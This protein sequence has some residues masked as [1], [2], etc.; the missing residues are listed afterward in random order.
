[1]KKIYIKSVLL[2]FIF[3]ILAIINAIIREK[4]YKIVLGD[5]IA[6]QIST[7]FFI[8]LILI[9]MYFFF[10]HI[11]KKPT[12]KELW[13]IGA[14]WLIATV[15]FEFIAGHYLFQNT[16]GK[17]LTDYNLLK[18]RIWSLVLLFTLIGPRIV[19]KD[20]NSNDINKI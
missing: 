2:W 14:S 19:T 10:N 8:I 18:G 16:W 7:I 12:K 15:L 17:L 4:T 6:H 5:L 9:I 3:A 20:F 11:N 13:I 1:M